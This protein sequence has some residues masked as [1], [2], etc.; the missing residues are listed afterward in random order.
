MTNMEFN[1]ARLIFAR[2]KEGMVGITAALADFDNI[3]KA[4][5][6]QLVAKLQAVESEVRAQMGECQAMASSGIFPG[7]I[8]TMINMYSQAL[9]NTDRTR[10]LLLSLT[11]IPESQRNVRA[12]LAIANR[13][14]LKALGQ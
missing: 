12:N 5:H 10:A 1:Q 7:E 8:Q 14:I 2:H 4:A 13:A 6:R 11:G 9:E 3:I